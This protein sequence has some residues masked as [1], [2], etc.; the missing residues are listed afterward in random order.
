[1]VPSVDSKTFGRFGFILQKLLNFSKSRAFSIILIGQFLTFLGAQL[2]NLQLHVIVQSC[3]KANDTIC[4]R[5]NTLSDEGFGDRGELEEVRAQR[6]V[7]RIS[8]ECIESR[9]CIPWVVFLPV[10]P[11]DL[12]LELFPFVGIIAEK[13]GYNFLDVFFAIMRKPDSAVFRFN[14]V[15]LAFGIEAVEI[16][17]NVVTSEDLEGPRLARARHESRHGNDRWFR[18]SRDRRRHHGQNSC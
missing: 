7:G 11:L 17:R 8:N 6:K 9:G 1:M 4:R 18:S 12:T 10:E 3:Q 2:D 13:D 5:Q 16:I 14:A 15:K